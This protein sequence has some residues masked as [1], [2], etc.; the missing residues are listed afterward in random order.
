MIPS[1]AVPEPLLWT[2]QQRA[3]C[4]CDN[5]YRPQLNKRGK[6]VK[7]HDRAWRMAEQTR[8]PG[9]LQEQ[10]RAAA[11]RYPPVD[12]QHH[13]DSR[14]ANA[15]Y[16]D[17][18]LWAPRRGSVFIELKKMG[19]DPSPAQVTKMT[20]L[21]AAG[22]PVYLCRP[23]CLLTGVI[24]RIMATLAGCEP[25]GEYALAPAVAASVLPDAPE[26]AATAPAAP[27]QPRRRPVRELPG[28]APPSD[29]PGAVGYVVPMAANVADPAAVRELEGWLR[30][31]GFPPVSVPFPIAFVTGPDRVAVLVRDADGARVWRGGSPPGPLPKGLADRLRA[32]RFEQPYYRARELVEYAVRGG[33]PSGG[34]PGAAAQ[35]GAAA[36]VAAA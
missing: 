6:L 26:L 13:N 21:A 29:I 3:R 12:Y 32:A 16:P 1:V 33:Q 20:S 18:H 4:A 19:C 25:R 15:G 17:V 36:R 2:P 23:C 28:G 7:R 24:D 9:C 10:T 27:P 31:A 22:H 8:D 35:L 11:T 30:A 34:E 14:K 5:A